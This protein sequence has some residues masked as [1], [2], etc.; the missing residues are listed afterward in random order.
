MSSTRYQ[1][2]GFLDLDN[3]KGEKDI[4]D[5]II[6]IEQNA[7]DGSGMISVSMAENGTSFGFRLFTFFIYY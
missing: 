7:F 4:E 1:I 3:D 5:R 2:K 6:D